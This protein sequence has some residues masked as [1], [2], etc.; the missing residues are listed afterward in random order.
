MQGYMKTWSMNEPESALAWYREKRAS[1]ELDPGLND[2]LHEHVLTDLLVGLAR[3]SPEQALELYD[4]VPRKEV[5]SEGPRW[6]AAA[7]AESMM[8][9]GDETRLVRLLE[10]HAGKDRTE[11][12]QGALGEFARNGQLDAGMALVD[13]HNQIPQERND[14][15]ESL[16]RYSLEPN[17]LKGGLDS[18]LASTPEAEVPEVMGRMIGRVA[19]RYNTA[20]REWVESQEPGMV[21]DIGRAAIVDRMIE[22]AQYPKAIAEAENIND[23]SLRAETRRAIGQEWLENDR[24]NAENALSDELIEQLQNQ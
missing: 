17:Q 3:S 5:D 2:E 16:F 23:A 8:E 11:I 22:T 19:R 18:V 10:L 12:L 15:L 6:M 20:A 13:Q 1:G 24:E 4:E 7:F 9:S 21:R 14:Y